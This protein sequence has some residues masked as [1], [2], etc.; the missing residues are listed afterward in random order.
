MVSYIL[1]RKGELSLEATPGNFKPVFS[2]PEEGELRMK[3]ELLDR[4]PPGTT[5]ECKAKG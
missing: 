3:Q 2:N 4:A 5:A 1:T